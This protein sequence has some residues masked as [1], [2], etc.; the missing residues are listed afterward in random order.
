[1]TNRL[2]LLSAIADVLRNAG[3]VALCGHIMPDGDSLGSVLALGLALRRMGKRVQLL[4][5]DPLPDQYLNLLPGAAEIQLELQGEW[6]EVLVALDC[7]DPERL[8]RFAPLLNSFNTVVIIDH[9]AGGIDFGHFYLN[10]AQSPATG[11][12]VYELLRALPADIDAA[13]ALCIYVSIN[14]D[15]GAFRYGLVR[16]A[17]H[18]IIAALMETGIDTGWINRQL[19]EEQPLVS[20]QVLSE[21]LKTLTVSSCGRLASMYIARETLNRLNARDE[22]ADGVI[23][24]PRTIKGVEL[25]MFFRELADGK[26]KVS[27]RSKYF[28]D[29]NK[30]ASQFG[31]GGHYRASG[32][33]VEGKLADVRRQVTEAAL[34]AL[35]NEQ[36]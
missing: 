18:R 15:T 7:S 5:P 29:V 1:M 17:T 11:E 27:F 4:S 6:P 21:A 26:W 20:L 19:Y 35:E 9:H 24:Y 3:S 22:H 10:D 16:P 31:G 2:E 13:I 14:T 32:C 23:S 36:K 25:A 33:T 12:L 34:A 8:G 28:L 30:L